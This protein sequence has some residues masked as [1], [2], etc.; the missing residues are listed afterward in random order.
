MRNRHLLAIRI[1]TFL[2]I[3]AAPVLKHWAN[4]RVLAS[5][6]DQEDATRTCS[7]IV[8]RLLEEYGKATIGAREVS[9]ADVARTAW[10]EGKTV[11]ATKVG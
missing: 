2:K 3:S 4:S 10:E 6:N 5:K 1:C 8:K 11:L 7:M 9:C